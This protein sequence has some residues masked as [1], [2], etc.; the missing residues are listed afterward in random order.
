[1][2]SALQELVARG[3]ACKKDYGKASIYWPSQASFSSI[4]AED[5]TAVTK[6]LE[7]LEAEVRMVKEARG[8]IEASIASMTAGPSGEALEAALRSERDA[9]A[10][11]EQ[12]VQI[13][14]V[15]QEESSGGG[16]SGS[17]RVQ[18][19]ETSGGAGSATLAGPARILSHS[20]KAALKHSLA[21]YRKVWVNRKAAV[22][23]F[24]ENMAD[25][26][27]CKP[28]KFYVEA[29]LETDEAAGVSI[30]DFPLT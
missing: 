24:L 30:R 23:D 11:L 1:M 13:I 5:V 12:R 3:V 16:S 21:R 14:R 25:G 8:V 26:A 7:G 20:E 27:G 4:S 28:A 29:G 10:A 6:K 19:G 22:V 18:G 17:K 2:E 9:V 15:A